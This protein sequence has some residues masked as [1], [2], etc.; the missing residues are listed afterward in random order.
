MVG[1]E[2]FLAVVNNALYLSGEDFMGEII[3]LCQSPYLQFESII[4]IP[5][6]ITGYPETIMDSPPKDP[7]PFNHP[8]KI[9]ILKVFRKDQKRGTSL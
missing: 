5:L 8:T 6:D 7:A 1:H 4:Q 9:V 2:G 3:A